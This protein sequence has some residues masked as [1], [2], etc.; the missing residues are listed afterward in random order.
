[1]FC[2]GGKINPKEAALK[3]VRVRRNMDFDIKIN[4]YALKFDAEKG[5]WISKIID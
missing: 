2:C 3:E 4:E 1:M 5:K